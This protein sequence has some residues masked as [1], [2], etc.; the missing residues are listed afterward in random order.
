M[1]RAV[2]EMGRVAIAIAGLKRAIDVT[3][4][5]VGGGGGGGSE[6]APFL[7]SAS[8]PAGQVSELDLE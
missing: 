1:R 5:N 6:T 7:T 4:R 8:A 3:Y 2:L